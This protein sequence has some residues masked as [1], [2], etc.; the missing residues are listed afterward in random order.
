MS[1]KSDVP[2][3]GSRLFF[4][5]TFVDS[6]HH[7]S[8]SVFEVF[9]YTLYLNE[10]SLIIWFLSSPLPWTCSHQ[11]QQFKISSSRSPA[12]A[13]ELTRHLFYAVWLLLPYC[14]SLLCHMILLWFLSGHTQP[15]LFST[16]SLRDLIQILIFKCHSYHMTPK[17][18][19]SSINSTPIILDP[20]IQ[21]NRHL[22]HNI[23]KTKLIFFPPNLLLLY[24]LSH[25]VTPLSTQVTQSGM[26]QPR[27]PALVASCPLHLTSNWILGYLLP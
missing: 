2:G 19:I 26:Y 9:L 1:S 4:I 20:Y 14:N 11:D 12:Q 13:P 6:V 23:F 22:R 18:L 7:S 27:L 16:L 3:R 10:S 25:F 21:I 17:I 24:S 15:L 8:T 5:L